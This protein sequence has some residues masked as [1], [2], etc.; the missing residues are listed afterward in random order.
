MRASI[1]HGAHVDNTYIPKPS[2]SCV[3]HVSIYAIYE[4]LVTTDEQIPFSWW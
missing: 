3:L 2:Q 1:S 4:W